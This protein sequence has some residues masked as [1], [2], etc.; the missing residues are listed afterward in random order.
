MWTIP[1]TICQRNQTHGS[2]TVYR[3]Q[4]NSLLKSHPF[5]SLSNYSNSLDGSSLI[6]LEFQFSENTTKRNERKR[7]REK[8]KQRERRIHVQ[9]AK[10]AKRTLHENNL[11]GRFVQIWYRTVLLPFFPII[12]YL[13]FAGFFPFS[14]FVT[15]YLLHVPL[16]TF[17]Y[18]RDVISL[19]IALALGKTRSTS[20]KWSF[21]LFQ[22]HSLV[23]ALKYK[24][25][26]Q[27]PSQPKH[28]TTSR[29][30]LKTNGDIPYLGAK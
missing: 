12:C 26:P 3:T 25:N 30:K 9:T 11:K 1:E 10:P 24:K 14:L 20:W 8:K 2:C 16:A 13:S 23:C 18:V 28:F 7:K 4:G 22:P 29:S 19:V 5:K 15:F 6:S 17:I 27:V 21:P